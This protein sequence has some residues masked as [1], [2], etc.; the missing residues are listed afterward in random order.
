MRAVALRESIP[1]AADP[2]RRDRHP[3]YIIIDLVNELLK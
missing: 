1:Y 2:S 3:L